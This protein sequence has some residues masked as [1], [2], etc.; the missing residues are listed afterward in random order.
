MKKFV[1]TGLIIIAVGIAAGVC[2]IAAGVFSSDMW[3]KAAKHQNKHLG[4]LDA[5]RKDVWVKPD[6]APNGLELDISVKSINIKFVAAAAGSDVTATVFQRFV[7]PD[8]E[9]DHITVDYDAASNKLTI[10]ENNFPDWRRFM[11]QDLTPMLSWLAPEYKDFD[12]VVITYGADTVFGSVSAKTGSGKVEIGNDGKTL[13]AAS[14]NVTVSS[15][16]VILKGIEAG[17]LDV[18]CNSGN[19]NVSDVKTSGPARIDNAS[20]NITLTELESGKIDIRSSSGWVGAERVKSADTFNIKS[21]SGN[22]RLTK[23]KATDFNAD[24]SSGR[25]NADNC[26]FIQM[27]T[28]TNSGNVIMNAL[29]TNNATIHVSSGKAD[30]QLA[31]GWASYSLQ[32]TTS[33]GAIFV[34]GSRQKVGYYSSV[35]GAD[36]IV[37]TAH[38]GRILVS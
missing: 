16:K 11:Y 2:S 18:T 7:K 36:K 34:G 1:I 20:G 13:N 26:A 27:N 9:S 32:L 14:V 38:S 37:I 25:I 21:S 5:P 24:V 22:V 23:C 10:K 17:S 29:E 31:R 33:S 19:I 8:H 28:K 12:D 4:M 30:I 6:D 15:G 3:I 35:V